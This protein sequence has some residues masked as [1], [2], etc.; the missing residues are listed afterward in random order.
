M[1]QVVSK[2]CI[3]YFWGSWNLL[4]SI[5]TSEEA[6]SSE[7]CDSL[8]LPLSFCAV[9]F[10]IKLLYFCFS[11]LMLRE[12]IQ[13]VFHHWN[14]D[15]KKTFCLR[16]FTVRLPWFRFQLSCSD[17]KTILLIKPILKVNIQNIHV[18]ENY[19]SLHLP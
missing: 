6:S 12:Q 1:P 2:L 3:L 4:I 16:T 9:E 5:F 18:Q 14:N 17:K 11:W 10:E 7:L 13:N 19:I 8:F 15:L